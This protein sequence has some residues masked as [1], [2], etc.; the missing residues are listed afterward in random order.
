MPQHK[1]DN[2]VGAKLRRKMGF[3]NP[4]ECAFL[5]D[6]NF[7]TIYDLIERGA[8]QRPLHRLVKSYYYSQKDVKEIKEQLKEGSES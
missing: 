6:I 2:R 3:F 7:W 1:M 4:R 8:I 5:C